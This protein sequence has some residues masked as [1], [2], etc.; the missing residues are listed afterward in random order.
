MA[1]G[2]PSSRASLPSRNDTISLAIPPMPTPSSIA[3]FTAERH[4]GR[5]ATAS[6]STRRA[7]R[8]IAAARVRRAVS[9]IKY[10]TSTA[11]TGAPSG[12]AVFLP[13][14]LIEPS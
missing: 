1:A 6:G 12:A 13:S 3:S 11:E 10:C 8:F 5:R 14:Y 7:S 9:V 2:P 4:F